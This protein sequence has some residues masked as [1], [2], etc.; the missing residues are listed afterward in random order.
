[1]VGFDYILLSLLKYGDRWR[2]RRR[3][4]HEHLRPS[5]SSVYK[6]LHQVRRTMVQLANRPPDEIQSTFRHMSGGIAL[7]VSHRLSISD[8]D[9]SHIVCGGGVE[10]AELARRA[11]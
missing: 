1:M 5:K 3:L 4:F 7:S 11:G 10:K 6:I 2:E 9:D 8:K